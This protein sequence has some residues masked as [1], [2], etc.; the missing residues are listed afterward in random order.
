MPSHMSK[1]SAVPFYYSCFPSG[2]VA[3]YSCYLNSV[4]SSMH[5]L[6]VGTLGSRKA[7]YDAVKSE[8]FKSSARIAD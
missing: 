6:S 3:C 8:L 2:V 5:Y 7:G 1:Y 4:L